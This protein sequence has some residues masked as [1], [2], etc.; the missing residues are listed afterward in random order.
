MGGRRGLGPCVQPVCALETHERKSWRLQS[1]RGRLDAVVQRR[2]N[3][4]ARFPEVGVPG[5]MN[6]DWSVISQAEEREEAF[7]VRRIVWA[8][9]EGL[10]GQTHGWL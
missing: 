6:T 5:A 8:K 3:A 10:G 7:P 9:A 1:L 4:Q 2:R